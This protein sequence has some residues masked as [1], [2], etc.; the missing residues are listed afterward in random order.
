[1]TTIRIRQILLGTLLVVVV[2]RPGV[3]RGEGIPFD[4]ERWQVQAEESRI[5]EY[6]GKTSL[7]LESGAAWITDDSFTN[8]TVEFDIAFSSA[9]GFMVSLGCIQALKCNKNT[10]PT[11]ITTHDLRFQKGLVVEDKYKRVARYAKEITKEVE[12]IAHSVGVTEPRLM[13]RRHVRITQSDGRSI[14]M[15]EILP[16]YNPV[17]KM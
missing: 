7:Y 12:M 9:R 11:G 3:C 2:F 15:N 16:S 14:P 1:M 13:R 4:S 8:G 17:A 6:Q 5:V 10:C